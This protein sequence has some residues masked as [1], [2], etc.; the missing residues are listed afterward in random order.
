MRDW[1]ALEDAGLDVPPI[2]LELPA[3]LFQDF[4]EGLAAS[5]RA[6]IGPIA[7]DDH[8]CGMGIVHFSTFMPP[9]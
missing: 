8:Y 7:S 1:R 3:R 6:L 2:P 4:W 5:E 9:R